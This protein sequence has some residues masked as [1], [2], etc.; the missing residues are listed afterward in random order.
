MQNQ[1]LKSRPPLKQDLNSQQKKKKE[2]ATRKVKQIHRANIT[3]LINK[4]LHILKN[5]T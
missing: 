5:I 3:K 2:K 1:H 4:V